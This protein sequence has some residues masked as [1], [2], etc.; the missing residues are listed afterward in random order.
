MPPK[1]LKLVLNSSCSKEAY[2]KFE[3][4]EIIPLVPAVDLQSARLQFSLKSPFKHHVWMTAVEK[5]Q[6]FKN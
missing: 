3:V 2:S 4:L 5:D 6:M 1:L